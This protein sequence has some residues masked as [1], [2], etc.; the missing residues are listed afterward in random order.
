VPPQGLL[1]VNADDLGLDV[2]TTDSILRCFRAGRV[3]S[4]SSLVFMSDSARAADLAREANL[5]T[6]LHLNLTEPF[7]DPSV[8]A[9]VRDRQARMA[10]HLSGSQVAYRVCDPRLQSLIEGCIQDQLSA[11]ERLYGVRPRDIDGHQ[12]VHTC[13]NVLLARSL[14]AV[15]G[16]RATFNLP[17]DDGTLG[18]RSVQGF[19]NRLV[20]LRFDSTQRFTYLRKGDSCRSVTDLAGIVSRARSES[21]EIMTH[22]GIAEERELL[23]SEDW[24]RAIAGQRF[25]TLSDLAIG[26]NLEGLSG[27]RP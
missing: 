10:R 8:P 5:P 13:V 25:G 27:A 17:P 7:T 12:H 11:F 4:A 1:I 2:P 24:A 19:I 15:K 18:K 9:A 22:P 6:R 23:M 14:R 21:V 16:M 20:R 3:G 26:G